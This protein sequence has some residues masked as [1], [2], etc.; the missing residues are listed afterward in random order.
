MTQTQGVKR[1]PGRPRLGVTREEV[2]LYATP[3]RVERWRLLAKK[4]KCSLSEA[5][6]RALDQAADREGVGV[7]EPA[8]S[9]TPLADSLLAFQRDYAANPPAPHPKRRAK[10]R[11]RGRRLRVRRCAERVRGRRD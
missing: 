10:P 8:T 1:Q 2:S 11:D 7:E 3:E 9:P 4:W 6:R 5:G